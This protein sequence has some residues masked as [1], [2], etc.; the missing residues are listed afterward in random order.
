MVL[1]LILKVMSESD[2]TLEVVV[3]CRKSERLVC[4]RKRC[5][6]LKRTV[7][8]WLSVLTDAGPLGDVAF[9]AGGLPD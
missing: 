8:V 7:S 2:L 5:L 4:V 1:N 3:R 6:R 9:I